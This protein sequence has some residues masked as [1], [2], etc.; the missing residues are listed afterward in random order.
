M[1]Y[2]IHPTLF[3]ENIQKY[4]INI[5][6]NLINLA[7]NPLDKYQISG[8]KKLFIFSNIEKQ[9][10][11]EHENLLNLFKLKWENMTGKDKGYYSEY[12]GKI[13]FEYNDYL[14]KI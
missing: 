5:Q 9:N 11:L 13:L 12:L 3:I 14:Q 2:F 4:S 8:L 6:K 1:I 10:I 7:I